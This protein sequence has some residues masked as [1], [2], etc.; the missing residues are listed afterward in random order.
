MRI[1]P[2]MNDTKGFVIGVSVEVVKKLI[3][4]HQKI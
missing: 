4:I 2:S 3:K 1:Y